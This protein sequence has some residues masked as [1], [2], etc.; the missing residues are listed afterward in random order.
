MSRS[1]RRCR[2]NG[3]ATT[4]SRGLAIVAGLLA[5]V[6][7]LPVA[8]EVGWNRLLLALAMGALAVVM[9]RLWWRRRKARFPHARTLGELLAM[10]PTDFELAVAGV[11]T[12]LGYREMRRAGGAGDLGADLIG[13]DPRGN[14]V[15]VQCKR[16]APGKKVGSPA[17]QSFIGMQ[18]THHQADRGLFVTTSTFTAPA[19][20]L[21][22]R[23]GIELID[24]AALTRRMRQRAR[25]GA[26]I[27]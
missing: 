2:R 19:I 24:G 7:V 6:I 25:G 1:R 12:D 16:F 14:T 13:R 21:A 23:H 20:A 3:F 11:L 18:T 27:V 8:D 5:L 15:V 17:L 9:I 22:D 10:T 26:W 4:V